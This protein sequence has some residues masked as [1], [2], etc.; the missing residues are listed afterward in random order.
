MF[1]RNVYI[2]ETVSINEYTVDVSFNKNSQLIFEG[3]KIDAPF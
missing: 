2:V 1:Y 3:D